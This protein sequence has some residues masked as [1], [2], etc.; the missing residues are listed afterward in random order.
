MNKY[1][2]NCKPWT[3]C[4]GEG[5]PFHHVR[6][7][8]VGVSVDY[9]HSRHTSASPL[10]LLLL[11]DDNDD[12][13]KRSLYRRPPSRPRRSVCPPSLLNVGPSLLAATALSSSTFPLRS[14]RRYS[15]C[16]L[17]LLS[18]SPFLPHRLLHAPFLL[19][20][21]HRSLFQVSCRALVCFIPFLFSVIPLIPFHNRLE[22]SRSFSAT[23]CVVP[24]FLQSCNATCQPLSYKPLRF[25]WRSR[26]FF[27]ISVL[28][29]WS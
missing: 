6:L 11:H 23:L 22:V 17:L 27:I 25:T 24:I 12:D 13:D 18:S 19:A 2:R 8:L 15:E 7:V 26:L 4:T 14:H 21:D 10:P 1:S 9:S 3:K 28:I 20:V 29:R 16:L 5:R